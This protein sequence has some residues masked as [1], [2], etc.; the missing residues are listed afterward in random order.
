M[1]L[2]VFESNP[3]KMLFIKTS[4]VSRAPIVRVI[5]QKIF[6]GTI[7]NLLIKKRCSA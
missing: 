6:Y 2:Y 7:T 4:P 3:V 5:L 1:P